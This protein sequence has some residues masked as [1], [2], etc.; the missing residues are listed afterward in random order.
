MCSFIYI[1]SYSTKFDD[2]CVHIRALLPSTCL[3]GRVCAP[4]LLSFNWSINNTNWADVARDFDYSKL[5]N[6]FGVT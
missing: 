4:V 2:G 6:R 1:T 3:F 5:R